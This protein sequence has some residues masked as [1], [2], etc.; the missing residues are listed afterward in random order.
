MAKDEDEEESEEER[1][2]KARI[3]TLIAEEMGAMAGEEDERHWRVT[4][5]MVTR[6]RKMSEESEEDEVLQTRVVGMAEV[7]ANREEWKEAISAELDSLFRDKEALRPLRGKE[8]E[9]FFNQA[10]KGDP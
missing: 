9:D 10:A 5:E 4:M 7:L 6:L 8:K 1:P 2:V 3:A